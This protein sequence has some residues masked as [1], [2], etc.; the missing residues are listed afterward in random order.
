M[1]RIPEHP[2]VGGQRD[3]EAARVEALREELLKLL[4]RWTSSDGK[5]ETA[6]GALKLYRFSQPTEPTHLLQEPAV[7]VVLRGRKEVI[8]GNQTYL[9]DCSQ[10][11]A[12]SLDAPVVAK[13]ADASHEEPCLCLTLAVDPRELAAL[14]VETDQ[15]APRDDHDGGAL[16]VSPVRAPLLD[17]LVRL[18]RLLD[19]P[20]EIPVLSPLILR[21]IHYRLLQSERYGRLAQMAIGDGRL[22]RVSGAILWIKEHF[23]EPLLIEALAKNVHMSPSA[24][25]Q[26]FKAVTAMSPIQYQ[27]RL[28]LQE[29]RRLLVSGAPS[30]EAVAHEVGYGSATQ[31]T[32]E[33]A[34]L[35]GHPPRRDVEHVCET[36]G[37][38]DLIH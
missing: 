12:V 15:H 21:E 35:F 5:H 26:N 18:L 6:I 30:A 38:R 25:H 3:R 8:L 19:A 22:R 17:G 32:R 27:K 13:I 4:N 11:L 10:Y 16:Y 24:L 9:Y 2:E 31:F 33:Y 14:I 34:R 37:V 36:A 20:E 28:R 1:T 29:A 7:Y 23:A